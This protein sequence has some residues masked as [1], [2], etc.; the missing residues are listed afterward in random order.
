MQ[1]AVLLGP[2]PDPDAGQ[3]LGMAGGTRGPN[4]SARGP[5]APDTCLDAFSFPL[6]EFH[7][8]EL[9]LLFR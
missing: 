8:S 1:N 7:L 9:H 2:K 6:P 5:K 4:I 3:W